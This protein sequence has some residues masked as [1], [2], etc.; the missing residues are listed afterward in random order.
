MDKGKKLPE[1]LEI[2]SLFNMG[3]HYTSQYCRRYRINV[4]GLVDQSSPEWESWYLRTH[5]FDAC[6][7]IADAGY[8]L[9]EIHFLYGFG[10]SG[11]KEEYD[12]AREMVH[13]AHRAGLKVF[14][15][16]QFFSVQSETFFLENPW[17]KQCIQL[18]ENGK[19]RRYDYNR[20]ALCFSHEKVRQYYLDGIKLGL[21][22][23]ELD[24]I[25][26]DNSYSKTCYCEKCQAEFSRYLQNRFS[27]SEAR[28][29]FGI[30]PLTECRLVPVSVPEDPLWQ[31]MTD[32]GMDRMNEMMALMYRQVK[33]INP[34][35]VF[36]G[37]PA[38]SRTPDEISVKNHVYLPETGQYFDLV[39]AENSMFPARTGDS[40]R[41]QAVAY[42]TAE[43]NGFKA[44]ASHH[45]HREGQLRWPENLRECSLSLLEA[46]AFGG[47]IPTA[48]WG[49][50]MDGSEFKTLYQRPIFLESAR[51]TA[52]FLT[53]HG[54]IFR[55]AVSDA[56]LGIYINRSSLAYDYAHCW[57][58]LQGLFQIF[59][60]NH[61]PFRMVD[62]DAL[63]RLEG[64]TCVIV[65]DVR[66][67]SST[68]FQAFRDF[69]AQGGKMLMTGE[70]CRYDELKKAR[71]GQELE[72][73]LT[74]DS[75][76]SYTDTPEA[77]VK[78]QVCLD[79]ADGP[80]FPYPKDAD[81]ILKAVKF[82]CQ[83]EYHITAPD[84]VA[85]ETWR[86]ASGRK[87]I[88]L[89]NYD[90]A[91]PA[92]VTLCLPEQAN[93]IRLHSPQKF[94]VT[95]WSTNANNVSLSG[96][97]TLAIISFVQQ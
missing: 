80:V 16:F 30:Y 24:G 10:L 70:A 13:N 85:V 94:G 60:K 49:I 74:D 77:C 14:G 88:A 31:A 72:A 36:G 4:M 92:E 53:E 2:P 50:R 18:D 7:A 20:D 1:S 97:D 19:N 87:V 33:R 45:L 41:H 61:I 22:Y 67:V 56:K 40:L 42:K 39:C 51:A 64:L 81:R 37:N 73:L 28:R 76:I 23:C 65:A 55:D 69:I 75:V 32:F 25:R 21:E 82:L 95:S 89:L 48:C 68:M 15:Y 79:G 62:M 3:F 96:L 5:G 90:N 17:A 71:P 59:L 63:E 35:A 84:F 6:R 34:E 26:L 43:V 27:E 86:N 9:I 8:Q 47:Q 44:Y 38:I 54:E 29:I 12:S 58:S 83:D 93:D 57:Y 78:N 52:D 11:E 46:L 66:A 91:N